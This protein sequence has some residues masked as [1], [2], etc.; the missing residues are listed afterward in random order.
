MHKL[1]LLSAVAALAGCSQERAADPAIENGIVAADVTVDNASIP[2]AT[3]AAMSLAETTWTYTNKDGKKVQESIDAAGN[4]VTSSGA[5]H[6]DHG[7]YAMRDGKACFT[8][9]MNKDGESCWTVADTAIGA[10]EET[11]SDKGEKLTVTRV[12]YVAVPP[13]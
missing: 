2:A 6:V 7:T 3:P 4:Y 13:M 12:A 5:E 11:V 1:V 8:S 9:K 10:S